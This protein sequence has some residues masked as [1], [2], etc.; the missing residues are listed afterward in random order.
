[1]AREDFPKPSLSLLCDTKYSKNT[2]LVHFLLRSPDFLETNKPDN[3][4]PTPCTLEA[5]AELKSC[6]LDAARV[7]LDS[8]DFCLAVGPLSGTGVPFE[9]DVPLAAPFTA[10]S[11]AAA[12]GSALFFSLASIIITASSAG[13]NFF[14]S[15]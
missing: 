14:S 10:A 13:G 2:N 11:R 1:M 4:E 12:D 5:V 3:T 6:T 15:I 8:F 9:V 7:C